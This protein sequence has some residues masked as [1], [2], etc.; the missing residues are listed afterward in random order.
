MNK[1]DS[2]KIGDTLDKIYEKIGIYKYID[3]ACT[4]S[5]CARNGTVFREHVQQLTVNSRENDVKTATTSINVW[6]S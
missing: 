6:A 2:I 1:Y 4:A 5:V 3:A